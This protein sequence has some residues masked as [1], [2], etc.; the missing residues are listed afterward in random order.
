MKKHNIKEFVKEYGKKYCEI[1]NIDVEREPFKWFLASLLFGAPIREK[2]AIKTYKI[3]EKYGY[4]SPEKIL[5]AGWDEIV[6]CLDEGG[7]ARYDFKTADK[8]LEACQNIIEEGGLEEIKKSK[9]IKNKLKNLAKGIGDTTINI[10]LREIKWAPHEPS[11]YAILAAK[12]H[13]LLEKGKIK[14][15]EG[16]DETELEIALMRL[17]RDFC[18]KNKCD[19]CPFPCKS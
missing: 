6:N 11:K 13:K 12:N 17:G 19:D 9:E 4:I 15:I 7:Y 16:V 5:E 1:L 3:F 18:R 8:I 2:T 10:F 14:K